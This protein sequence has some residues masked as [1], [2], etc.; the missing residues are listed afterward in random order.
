MKK[1]LVCQLKFD[2]KTW[3]A[4]SVMMEGVYRLGQSSGKKTAIAIE[5]E[6]TEHINAFI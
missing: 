3:G 5:G 6:I 4:V 1:D 2:R